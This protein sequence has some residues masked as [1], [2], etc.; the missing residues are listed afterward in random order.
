MKKFFLFLLLI[1]SA[2][3]CKK[4]AAIQGTITESNES[5]IT[6]SI[7]RKGDGTGTSLVYIQFNATWISFNQPCVY[8]WWYCW[9]ITPLQ[10]QDTRSYIK[11]SENEK[12]IR[13]GID[14]NINPDYH[15]QFIKGSN[16][17][18]SRRYTYKQQHC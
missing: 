8:G 11:I 12:L 4:T 10:R 5:Q 6:N 7:V 14:N 15:K 17:T 9:V 16:F 13:F 3:S 1:V 18:F 2:L